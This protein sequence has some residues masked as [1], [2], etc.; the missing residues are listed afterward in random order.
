MMGERSYHTYLIWFDFFEVR[1]HV[2]Q[3]GP[4]LTMLLRITLDTWPLALIT[5]MPHLAYTEF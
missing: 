4:E 5:Y 2:S 3:V 1:S